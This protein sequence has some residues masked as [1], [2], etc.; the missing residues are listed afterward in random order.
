MASF[1]A[2]A[3]INRVGKA[4]SPKKEPF[5]VG[6]AGLSQSSGQECANLIPPGKKD[7]H[8]C[9]QRNSAI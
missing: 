4:P 5:V 3:T 1:A 6:Q 8:L 7:K 2:A 9:G